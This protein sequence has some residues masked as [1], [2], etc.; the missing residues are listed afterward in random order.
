MKKFIASSKALLLSAVLS[1]NVAIPTFANEITVELISQNS[2]AISID[3]VLSEA[4]LSMFEINMASY[5]QEDTVRAGE[6]LEEYF[7]IRYI[8]NDISR[9]GFINGIKYLGFEDAVANEYLDGEITVAEAVKMAVKAANLE[10]LALTYS[11]NDSAKAMG[12]LTFYGINYP[13]NSYAP[14]IACA[15]DAGLVPVVPNFDMNL[16]KQVAEMLLL[17]I[18][19]FR[20]EARNY[21]GKISEIDIIEKLYGRYNEFSNVSRFNSEELLEIGNYLVV[22]DL[23]TGYNLKYDNYDAQF[24]SGYT[25]QYGHSDITHAVQL[26]TLLYSEG[27]DGKVQL[28][29]KVSAFEYMV[30]WGD[31]T[32]IEPS[33]TYQVLPVG[34][35]WVAYALEY[36]LVIEFDNKTGMNIFDAVISEYSKKWSENQQLNGTF[37]PSL[38]YGAWWQPLYSSTILMDDTKAYNSIYNN[39]ISTTDGYSLH[40]FTIN[41]NVWRFGEYLK[42]EFSDVEHEVVSEKRYVNSAFYRYLNG[43]FE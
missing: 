26:I 43:E 20:G 11:R 30:E 13:N 41:N 14:Y 19:E 17:N 12:L 10:E 6:Y 22:N 2:Q 21:I 31:P 29:P 4:L 33:S 5:A 1:A 39:I 34:D 36:D 35:K 40:T 42:K 37:D 38:I 7:N 3:E 28:E 15:V 27:I 18:A 8:N 9:K 32:K 23:S 25:I 24:L 16:T